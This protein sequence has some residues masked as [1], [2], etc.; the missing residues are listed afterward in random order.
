VPYASLANYAGAPQALEGSM[1]LVAIFVMG[2][3]V[4]FALCQLFVNRVAQ[5][6]P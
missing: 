5:T 3:P 2:S 4:C 1:S 6:I